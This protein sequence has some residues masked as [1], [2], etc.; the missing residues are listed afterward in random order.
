MTNKNGG[1]LSLSPSPIGRLKNSGTINEWFYTLE[2]GKY[3]S[4][5]DGSNSALSSVVQKI[6]TLSINIQ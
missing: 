2:L 5:Q 6:N 4:S 3:L 1:P